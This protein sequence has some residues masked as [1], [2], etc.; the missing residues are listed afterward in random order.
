MTCIHQEPQRHAHV[1]S[2]SPHIH[3]LPWLQKREEDEDPDEV[4]EV[5]KQHTF[6]YWAVD[7]PRAFDMIQLRLHVMRQLLKV[8]FPAP[9][10]R[11]YLWEASKKHALVPRSAVHL[12][13]GVGSRGGTCTGSPGQQGTTLPL[14]CP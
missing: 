12:Y 5:Q 14:A 7:L 10:K 4:M 11:V 2:P 6:S 3:I 9:L 8:G 1:P 13:A